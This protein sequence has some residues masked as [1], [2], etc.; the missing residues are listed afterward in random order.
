MGTETIKENVEQ[1]HGPV[2]LSSFIIISQSSTNLKGFLSPL[3]FP[4]SKRIRGLGEIFFSFRLVSL[5]HIQM[6]FT[7]K[8]IKD[9]SFDFDS[10]V[11]LTPSLFCIIFASR[12]FAFRL[13]N[14][15][16]GDV[17]TNKTR[18]FENLN[19]LFMHL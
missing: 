17:E 4:L 6:K 9:T 5:P 16:P 12:G 2:F 3:L 19:I 15:Y 13:E 8:N 10:A 7:E 1:N 11:F 14:D 18:P